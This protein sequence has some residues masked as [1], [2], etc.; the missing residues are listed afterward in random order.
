MLK[1]ILDLV[2]VV[3]LAGM[4]VLLIDIYTNG[5]ISGA[6]AFR[7]NTI[8]EG[9]AVIGNESNV[10]EIGDENLTPPSPGLPTK[11]EEKYNV[12]AAENAS[13]RNATSGL[14]INTSGSSGGG[15]HPPSP[16]PPNPPEFVNETVVTNGTHFSLGVRPTEKWMDVYGNLTIGGQPAEIGDEV[17]A[18]D[19]DG[20]ICG[21]FRLRFEGIY[22]FLHVYGDNDSTEEDEGAKAGDVLTFRVYDRSENKELDAVASANASWAEKV[23]IGVDL[24]A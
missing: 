5:A 3:F 23:M 8:A 4:A 7:S 13:G 1:K 17:A 2:L 10:T 19:S 16:K 9:P 15:S 18:F 12:T 24:R 6:F 11:P 22:G 21:I 20:L 14:G